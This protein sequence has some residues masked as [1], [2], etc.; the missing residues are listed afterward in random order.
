[1]AFSLFVLTS[2]ARV[3]SRIFST[4]NPN[5]TC[6]HSARH[7]SCYGKPVIS[8]MGYGLMQLPKDAIDKA[9]PSII[10]HTPVFLSFSIPYLRIC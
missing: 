9:D 1:M 6:G 5:G 3:S 2:S 4:L 8:D 10:H 7:V